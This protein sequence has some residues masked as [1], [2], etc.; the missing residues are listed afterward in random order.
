MY[1]EVKPFSR[2]RA[3]FSVVG[4]EGCYLEC[5]PWFVVRFRVPCSVCP[6]R[7]QDV[8]FWDGRSLFG[9]IRMLVHG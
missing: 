2:G 6:L 7:W 3:S 1:S 5:A 8:S 4:A 9:V